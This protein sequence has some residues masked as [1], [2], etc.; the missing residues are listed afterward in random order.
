M[1]QLRRLNTAATSDPFLLG[2]RGLVRSF[3]LS[4]EAFRAIER[5]RPDRVV[6]DGDAVLVGQPHGAVLNLHYAFPD[7]DAFARQF[8]EVLRRLLPT[9]RQEDAPLG[10]RLRLTDRT[11]RPYLE[12][13]LFAQAFELSGEWMA[14]SLAELPDDEGPGEDIADGYKLRPARPEDAE[15]I[16]ELDAVAFL[17]PVL[18]TT[19]VRGQLSDTPALRMLVE[20]ASGR[21]VGFLR[22]RLGAPGVGHVANVAVH[23]ELQR[24]GLGEAM[25]RWAFA[26]FRQEGLRRATL[27]VTVDN[28]AAIALY[29]KL[30]FTQGD[31]GLDYR[32]PID[33][34]EVRQVLEKHRAVHIRVRS[35][36]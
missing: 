6:V 16:V 13:V 35:R 3:T 23:P 7:R 20:K 30:G 28:G 21:A 19:A 1:K 34:D 24:R 2:Q 36:Y 9:V 18:T 26:W 11:N 31:V 4:E 14:M 5:E 25:M 17:T 22:L 15:S 33:G 27:T 32:R 29:R 8:P 12:P 10:F